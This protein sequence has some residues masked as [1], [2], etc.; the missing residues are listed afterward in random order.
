MPSTP[1][2]WILTRGRKQFSLTEP[3]VG[4]VTI[5]DIAFATAHINRFTGHVGVYS[6]AEHCVHVA[7]RVR[8]LGGSIEE[9]L[10]ALLHDATEA[11]C[12]D[13]SSPLKAAMRA[14]MVLGVPSPYDRIEFGIWYV[15]AEAFDLELEWSHEL[16]AI[17]KQADHELVRIEAEVL[18]GPEPLPPEWGP[19]PAERVDNAERY[20]PLRWPGP[21]AA[22]RYLSMFGDLVLARHGEM[23]R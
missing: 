17:V 14:R 15:I 13:A 6:V 23:L 4:D 1:N 10:V 22:A 20:A 9:Q 12:G 11:Y 3:R 21:L 18:W 7:R 8:D 16:P 19:L 5:K 2:T